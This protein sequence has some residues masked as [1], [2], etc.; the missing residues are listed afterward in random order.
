MDLQDVWVVMA[1]YKE[2][3]AVGVVVNDVRSLG[4]SVVVVDDGSADQ[5]SAVARRAGAD[6]VMHPF[7]LGQGAALQTGIEYA[8]RRNAKY[9]VTFDADGQHDPDDIMKML[10]ALITANADIVCGS[11]F[12]GATENMPSSR[13]ALLKLAV[14]FTKATTGIKMTDAHN[15]FRVMTAD[16]AKKIK[17]S[18]NR[19]AHASEIISMIASL[20]LK[21][22]EAPVSVKYTPYSLAKG[23]RISGALNILTD[24]IFKALHR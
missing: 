22:T 18:Q 3:S 8:L 4:Y 16:C 1:A 2:V 7:N 9:M 15:G 17:I 24:L 12:Q 10:E 23:Q 6:V 14:L 21:Y 13:K 19:M 11:R 5:T 20:R